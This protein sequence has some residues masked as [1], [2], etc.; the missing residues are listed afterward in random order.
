MERIG[1][2]DSD[3]KVTLEGPACVL[4]A[5]AAQPLALA[6]HELATNAAKYGALAHEGANLHVSWATDDS[7]DEPRVVLRWRETG[8]PMPQFPPARSGY[9]SELIQRSLPYQLRAETQ[10][11]FGSSEVRCDISVPLA[12]RRPS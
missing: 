12:P 7:T 2:N 5:S 6:L 1:A 11:E 10:L 9:G 8:V 3:S 4:P